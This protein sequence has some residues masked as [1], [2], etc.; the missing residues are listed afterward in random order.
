MLIQRRPSLLAG[1]AIL[2]GASKDEEK[3]VCE[4]L[5]NW[6]VVSASLAPRTLNLPRVQ[7]A[8]AQAGADANTPL[9]LIGF[10]PDGT[11]TALCPFASNVHAMF[12]GVTLVGEVSDPFVQVPRLQ[13]LSD[14]GKGPRLILSVDGLYSAFGPNATLPPAFSAE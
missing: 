13:A 9:L 5:P 2:F 14:A 1:L 3:S 6:G 4:V 10:G 11:A 8:R 7:I 12:V